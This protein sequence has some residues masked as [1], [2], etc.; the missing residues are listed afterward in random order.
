[1][2]FTDIDDSPFHDDIVWAWENGIT[3][4]CTDTRFCPLSPVTRA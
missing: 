3:I 1:M 4:G 2:P